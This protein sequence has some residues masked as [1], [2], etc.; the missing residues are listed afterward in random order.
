MRYGVWWGIH[1]GRGGR[2]PCGYRGTAGDAVEKREKRGDEW[3]REEVGFV[4]LR[5]GA[6]W[7]EV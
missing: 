2:R 3:L 5:P 6:E 1:D 7:G 4:R